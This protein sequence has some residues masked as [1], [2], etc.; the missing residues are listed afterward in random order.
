MRIHFVSTCAF[1]AFTFC[2][3][4]VGSSLTFA[5]PPSGVW[6]IVSS[7][8]VSTTQQNELNGIACAAQN[9]CW[10][11]GDYY[12]GSAYQ[13]LIE[14]WDGNAW[15]MVTSANMNVSA[16]QTNVLQH[17]TCV[18]S[19]DCYAVGNYFNGV[20]RQT[21]IEH[22]DGTSWT[23]VTSANTQPVQSNYLHEVTCAASNDCWAVGY[24]N[25]SE[26]DMGIFTQ[27]LIQHWNGTV[28]SMVTSPNAT[29][30]DGL[31]GVSCTSTS[32][33]WSVGFANATAD[34]TLIE[35]WDGTSWSI[36][37]SPNNSTTLNNLI[38]GVKCTSDSDC[39]AAGYYDPGPGKGYQTLI[40]HWDGIS[41]TI[42]NSANTGSTRNNFLFALTCAASNDCI[43]T[44]RA[45]NGFADQTLIEHWDG[46]VWTISST[47]DTNDHQYNDFNYAVCA[48]T[49]ECF[50]VGY[51]VPSGSIRQTLI[52]Q[53]IAGLQIT[54]LGKEA[55]GKFSISGVG[56][57]F[58]SIDIQMSPDLIVPFAT[59]GSVDA[60]ATGAFEYQDPNAATV[61]RRFYRAVYP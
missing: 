39:W 36:V 57:P 37:S 28:W 1:I 21:L 60:D 30:N 46:N 29:P 18:A 56:A 49:V 6:Q 17:V 38:F 52:E 53:F 22:W 34:Q 8:N 54:S 27:T 42:A 23:I 58:S 40:E 15:S 2:L 14:H 33:C 9:D 44:G 25:N 43:A 10:A 41:W 12:T 55:D 35:H 11:V 3:V 24:Y 51:Y 19:T 7:P 48:S 47:P 16:P 13:T 26:L 20:V 61:T 32:D 31:Y 5:G 59:I 4:G 45:Y 50:S